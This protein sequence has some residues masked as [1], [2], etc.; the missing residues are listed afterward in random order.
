MGTTRIADFAGVVS[1]IA[2]FRLQL[3]THKCLRTLNLGS[4]DNR[5]R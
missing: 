2:V 4:P 3:I 5:R 1:A